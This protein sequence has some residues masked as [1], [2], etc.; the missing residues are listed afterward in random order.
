[1]PKIAHEPLPHYTALPSVYLHLCWR[2]HHLL[3]HWELIMTMYVC[4]SVC[5][6]S[7]PQL[8][9][10]LRDA[11]D[12]SPP[13]S[14]LHGISQARILEWVASSFSRRS[15]RSR[16]WPLVSYVSALAGGF[17]TGEPPGD[18]ISHP[19]PISYQLLSSA[20]FM[21]WIPVWFI[22]KQISLS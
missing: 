4:V 16:D 7:A 13:G 3:W 15:S 2:N 6:C 10:T 14:S 21:S 12:Y 17:F 11:M 22:L 19:N 9:P 1:M 8:C 20:D 5:A 18:P